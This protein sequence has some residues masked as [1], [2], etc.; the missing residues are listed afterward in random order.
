[1]QEFIILSEIA[2]GV[3]KAHPKALILLAILLCCLFVSHNII[4]IAQNIKKSRGKFYGF[5][6]DKEI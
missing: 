2:W 6:S 3:F 1:M 5:I 4:N